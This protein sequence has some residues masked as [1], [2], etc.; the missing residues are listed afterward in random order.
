MPLLYGEGHTNID[1]EDAK[2]L[3]NFIRGVDVFDEVEGKDERWKL[4][5]IYHA[6]LAVMGA[7]AAKITDNPDKKHTDAGYRFSKS[8]T[9]FSS[10]HKNR[11]KV[12]FAGANDGM[13]HA[14]NLD[15]G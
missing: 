12:V 1:I 14:F 11:V 8:Y 10:S 9:T 6:E 5:D 15:T 4:G 7:P 2:K 3:I 13:L